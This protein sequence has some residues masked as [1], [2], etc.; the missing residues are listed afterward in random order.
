VVVAGAPRTESPTTTTSAPRPIR[1]TAT[2]H[3]YRARSSW[4]VGA[5]VSGADTLR[6][7]ES[8]S[9]LIDFTDHLGHHIPVGEMRYVSD[10]DY[11]IAHGD[12]SFFSDEHRPITTVLLEELVLTAAQSGQGLRSPLRR[13]ARTRC[14]IRNSPVRDALGA[15]VHHIQ[16]FATTHSPPPLESERPGRVV[17]RDP[18]ASGPPLPTSGPCQRSAPPVARGQPYH[19]QQK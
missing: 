6:T 5:V 3:S 17:V 7:N 13:V 8:E 1:S 10:L 4:R 14:G 15:V 16:E 11:A 19:E 9:I 2:D 12:P 18:L